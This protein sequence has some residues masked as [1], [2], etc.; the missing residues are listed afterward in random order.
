MMPFDHY[1]FNFGFA[2]LQALNCLLLIVWV[3]FSLF[4]LLNLR[5]KHINEVARVLWTILIVIVPILGSAAY[6]IVR[7]QEEEQGGVG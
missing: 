4:S 1:N 5:K 6:W 3:G 2:I 7:P